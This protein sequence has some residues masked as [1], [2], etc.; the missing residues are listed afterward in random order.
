MTCCC[1]IQLDLDGTRWAYLTGIGWH[2]PADHDELV[3]ARNTARI[4]AE[5]EAVL[6][7][8]ATRPAF[9]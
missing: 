7:S 8:T 1:R 2:N 9:P 6:R 3:L 5:A 4:E